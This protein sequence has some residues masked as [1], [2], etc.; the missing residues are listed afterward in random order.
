MVVGARVIADAAAYRLGHEFGNRSL[1]G[2]SHRVR[3]GPARHVVG[4]SVMSR[5]FRQIV[6]GAVERLRV[7]A[8]VTITR[9]SSSWP[10]VEVE[11]PYFA[12]PAGSLS[13]L[14]T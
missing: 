8:E 1:T 5:R 12:R 10:V 7:R 4:L 2:F 3:Q 11:T 9:S 13:K 14:N 6:S